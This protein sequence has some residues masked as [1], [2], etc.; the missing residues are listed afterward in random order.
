MQPVGATF[1]LALVIGRGIVRTLAYQVQKVARLRK[2]N[3]R[4]FLRFFPA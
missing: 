1:F 2:D 4:I 3:L